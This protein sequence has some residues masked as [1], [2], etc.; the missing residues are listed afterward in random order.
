MT[1]IHC[2]DEKYWDLAE[3]QPGIYPGVI[4]GKADRVPCGLVGNWLAGRIPTHTPA[5]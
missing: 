5:E 3:Y 2:R 1:L 4:R